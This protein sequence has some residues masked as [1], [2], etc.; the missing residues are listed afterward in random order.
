MKTTVNNLD[1]KATLTNIDR[2]ATLTNLNRKATLTNRDRVVFN[3]L[4]TARI[5]IVVYYVFNR[6]SKCVVLL[7]SFDNLAASMYM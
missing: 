4:T 3:Y 2:K 7:D 5:N 6:H 1:R